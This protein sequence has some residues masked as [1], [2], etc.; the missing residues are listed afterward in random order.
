MLLVADDPLARRALAALLAAAD[1][2]ELVGEASARDDLEAALAAARPEVIIWDLGS[3]ASEAIERFA[4][5]QRSE[6]AVVALAGSARDAAD[7]LAAGARGAVAREIDAAALTAAARAAASGLVPI[8]EEFVGAIL[9][10]RPAPA[11]AESLTPRELEVLE[12]LA[13]GLSNKE[14]GLALGI[15]EHTAKFH[16]TSVLAKLGAQGR[17]EAVVRAARLGIVA[18]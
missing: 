2:V 7:A 4:E 1:G 14:I 18:L 10:S 12:R 5:A 16:V 11:P 8:G 6:L 3:D 17:T 15:S 9:R 13:Q